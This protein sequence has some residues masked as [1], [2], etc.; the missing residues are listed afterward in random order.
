M[1][2]AIPMFWT[3]KARHCK[4]VVM[5]VQCCPNVLGG[6]SRQQKSE[7]RLGLFFCLLPISGTLYAYSL[8]MK[9]LFKKKILKTLSL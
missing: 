1:L 2:S 5:L 9:E 8:Y 7:R 3:V 4:A 6:G